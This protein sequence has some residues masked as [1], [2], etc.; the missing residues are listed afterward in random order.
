MAGSLL[1]HI[2]HSGTE[3]PEA[4]SG[5]F[6]VSPD[7]LR[8]ELLKMTDWY[9]HE[10]FSRGNGGALVF[11]YSRLVCDVERFVDEGAEP[12]ARIGMGVCYTRGSR[13]QPLRIPSRREEAYALYRRHHARL[14]RMVAERLGGGGRCCIVDGHS[15]ASAPLPY[16]EASGARCRRRPDICVGADSFHTPPALLSQSLD[17]FRSRGLDVAVNEPFSGALVPL[18]RYRTDCR[19]ASVMIEVNKKLYM[20]E[21]TGRKKPEF[22][23]VR[24]LIQEY[25]SAV[26]GAAAPG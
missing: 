18:S 19:V 8:D 24:R 4:F 11:P 6:L 1:V 2:P 10:L 22:A 23:R 15:F 7:G 16:E 9:T 3:I 14:E 20:D 12:M 21:E 5:S 26:E 17:F 13:L 25:L